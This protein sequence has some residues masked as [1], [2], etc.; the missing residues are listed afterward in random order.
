MKKFL[1]VLVLISS[2]SSYSQNTLPIT[3][4]GKL[5]DKDSG[6]PLEFATVS[7]ISAQPDQLPQGGVTD[8]EGS[9]RINVLPGTYTVKWEYI[10]FKSI[11][12]QKQVLTKDKDYGVLFLAQDIAKLDAA[13]IVA[14]KTTVDIR[15]DKKIYNIG[16]DLTVQGGTASDV[17]D[18]VPSVSVDVEGNVALRGNNSVR[19]LI[20][21]RPSALVGFSGAEALRQ[22]PSEAIERIEV[23]TSPSA[24][25][26]AEGTAG[27]LNIILRKNRIIGFNGSINMNTSYPERYGISTNLNFRTTKWNLFTNTG[28][29]YRTSPGNAF[30]SIEYK[31]PMPH[32]LIPLY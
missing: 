10:T 27:I 17:L 16:K 30:T 29:R 18:N 8:S 5:I 22:I 4:K 24:R 9:Y 28:Y 2:A 19:I 32:Q 20:D 7:F 21:G 26:D 1:F 15:L 3:V 13:I 25:Y 23:I 31:F 6:A 14:E 12:K 11:S